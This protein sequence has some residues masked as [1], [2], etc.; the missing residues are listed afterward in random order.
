MNETG[1]FYCMTP[2][3]TIATRQIEGSKKNKTR[4]ILNF[5]CNADGTDKFIIY[6]I[7]SAICSRYFKNKY[8]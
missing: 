5:A 6:F 2:D 7:S 8:A 1:L 4:I 3:K